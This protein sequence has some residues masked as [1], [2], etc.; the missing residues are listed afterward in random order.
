MLAREGKERKKGRGEKTPGGR[1]EEVNR[2]LRRRAAHE[3]GEALGRDRAGEGRDAAADAL[4]CEAKQRRDEKVQR[5]TKKEKSV[6]KRRTR[7]FQTTTQPNLVFLGR[8]VLSV[9]EKTS[10]YS[11]ARPP[12]PFVDV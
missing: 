10:H 12:V 2:P 1:E 6:A 4:P 7:L 5:W 8:P 3:E 11:H 9:S